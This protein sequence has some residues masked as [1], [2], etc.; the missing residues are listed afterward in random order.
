MRNWTSI[1]LPASPDLR[2]QFDRIN[3]QLFELNRGG[4]SGSGAPGPQGPAGPT[5]P[6]GATGATGPAGQF[7]VGSIFMA[8][9][10]T[11]PATL[12]GY[13]TWSALGQGKVLIGDDGGTYPGGAT[14]GAATKAISA[15]SGAA[16][17]DHAAHTHGVTID[18]ESTHKHYYSSIPDH[19]HREMA[20]G[21][22]VASTGGTHVMTSVTTGG[23]LR[24]IATAEHTDIPNP[25]DINAP[26]QTDTADAHTHT[27]GT[28]SGNTGNPS[29]TLTH[30]VT[31]PAS[32][33]DLN[34]VQ[35]YLVVFMWKRDL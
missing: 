23:T 12:L 32:H 22:L 3:K 19:T 26:S 33:T 10:A 11:N 25:Q 8:V 7:P 5:G 4:G 34:V 20:Q 1:P 28:S 9:T 29:A 31:Q 17:G 2:Y 18:A 16:V 21:D 30:S 35:P 15:H 27:V 13:G 6:A 24:A 14:G